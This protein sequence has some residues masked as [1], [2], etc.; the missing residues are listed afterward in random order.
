MG[1]ME[2]PQN[3]RSGFRQEDIL[4]MKDV[5]LSQEEFEVEL[6]RT[7]FRYQPGP[8]QFLPIEDK[9]SEFWDMNQMFTP[10]VSRALYLLEAKLNY[11]IGMN[12]LQQVDTSD[13]DE[14]PVNISATGMRFATDNTYE[15]GDHVRITLS[16]PL[17]PPVLVDLLAEVVHM[18]PRPGKRTQVGVAFLY[19][20]E[21]EEEAVTRYVFK[22]HREAIRMKYR[23]RL[24][25]VR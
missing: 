4:R 2:E 15:V 7:G 18:K 12:I 8:P 21:D 3:Q 1:E 10:D 9:R 17:S 23:G 25:R 16:L 24:A 6:N 13:L 22:R 19:R 5:R 14:H 11:L 20:S